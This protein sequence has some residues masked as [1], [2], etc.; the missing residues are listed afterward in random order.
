MSQNVYFRLLFYMQ[1]VYNAIVVK[2][3]ATATSMFNVLQLLE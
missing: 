1:I 3:P 2:A